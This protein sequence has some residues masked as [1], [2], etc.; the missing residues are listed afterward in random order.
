MDREAIITISDVNHVA[1]PAGGNTV[2]IPEQI[3]PAPIAPQWTAGN[4]PNLAQIAEPV[5]EKRD[6]V[7]TSWRKHPGNDRTLVCHMNHLAA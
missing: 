6:A 4:I 7:P 2:K 5:I 1:R 3:Q